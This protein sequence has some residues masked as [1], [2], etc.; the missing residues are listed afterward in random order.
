VIGGP[1][2]DAGLTG[3]KIIIDT[4]G[5]WG[6]HGGGAFSGKVRSYSNVPIPTLFLHYCATFLYVAKCVSVT[7]SYSLSL[8]LIAPLHVAPK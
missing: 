3:R 5:G 4:Y 6:A 2:G 1:H 8:K 7:T